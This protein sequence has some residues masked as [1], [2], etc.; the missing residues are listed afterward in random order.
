M[1]GTAAVEFAILAP[2]YFLMLMGMIAFGIYL[3][4]A[5]SLQQLAADA[6]RASVAGLDQADRT[7]IAGRFIER[8]AGGYAFI[9]PEKLSV[10]AGGSTSDSDQFV[11][12]LSFEAA[13]LPIWSLM[14]GLPLPEA[15]IV[16]RSTIR[17]GGI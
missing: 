13:D 1:S 3:G 8:N 4:A 12:S 7:E 9:R 16:R 14:R 15:T 6:A 11:V 5:H 2:V 17:I 10:S